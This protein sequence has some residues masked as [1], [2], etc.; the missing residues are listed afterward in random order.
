M[1]VLD[2]SREDVISGLSTANLAISTGI[3]PR[4]R[5]E[6]VAPVHPLGLS[7]Q[8]SFAAMGDVRLGAVVPAIAVDGRRVGVGLGQRGVD[9]VLPPAHV[10]E[11]AGQLV[12]AGGHHL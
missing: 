5:M 8:G 7:R 10:H 2:G 12:N 6:V 4:M 1:E 11:P 3:V 9:H